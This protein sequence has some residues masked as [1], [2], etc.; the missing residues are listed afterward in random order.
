MTGKV[1]L[2]GAGPSNIGLF[3]IRG[4]ELL[5]QAQVVLYDHLVGQ[6]ILSLIP[7][8]AKCIEVEKYMGGHTMPQER[9]EQIN[10]VLLKE[11]Q[12]G[13]RVV[14]L[15]G[16]DPLLFDRG[17]EELL[18]LVKHHIPFEIVPGVTS[19][20][21]V[22]A[23]NGIPVIHKDCMSSLHIIAGNRDTDLKGCT[24]NMD[25]A[26]CFIDF[27]ALVRTKGTLVF[28]MGISALASICQ[29]LM[30]GGM[31]PNMPA[32]VL[33]QGT[34]A[35]QKKVVSTIDALAD[36]VK[37]QG[38]QNPAI[39]VV[40][41]ACAYAD[42]FSWYEK[43]PLFGNKIIVTSPK[44]RIF[45]IATKLRELGA[46][47]LELPTI[48]TKPILQNKQL[49][50][51]I[52][53]LSDYQYIVF[54]SPSGVNIFFD[55][56]KEQRADIRCIGDA[57]IAV[58]GPG[59]KKEVEKRGLHVDL[60]PAQYDGRELGIMLGTICKDADK[61]LI[62]R[63]KTGNPQI[64]EEIK[65]RKS[66]TITDLPIYD[67]IYEP[68][69]LLIDQKE[70]IKSGKVSI[71]VF[72]SA[73][74]VRG[75]AETTKDLDYTLLKAVCIGRHTRAEAEALGMKT[76]I[77]KEATVDSLVERIVE[78]AQTKKFN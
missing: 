1:W 44:E 60:M 51:E 14:H 30:K 34:T 29:G 72:T 12:E 35:G 66:V 70:E 16:G 22:P 71:V 47:V 68:Q 19:A 46:Q 67:T 65:R 38:M 2:V 33:Q 36:E 15:K 17:D 7:E 26:D 57:K 55:A 28:L 77:A 48:K 61:L 52:Q 27:E 4:K 59:A 5:E 20:I 6:D 64:I 49:K 31:S 24:Q 78:L 45:P 25:H 39:L 10:Q 37:K 56:L 32:A 42:E 50:E 9:Q 13:K 40:G 43:L 11:V 3:T 21:S 23:Y 58:I 75:F 73:S 8:N 76:A 53:H 69:S 63:A 54:T 41:T 62:P 74:T 18:C